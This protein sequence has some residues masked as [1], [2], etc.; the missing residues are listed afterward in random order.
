M[1]DITVTKE[2]Y[3]YKYCPLCKYNKVEETDDPCNDCLAHGSNENTHKPVRY[4]L[5][6]DKYTKEDEKRAH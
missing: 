1:S 4:V 2:V 3:Y 5:D 6:T